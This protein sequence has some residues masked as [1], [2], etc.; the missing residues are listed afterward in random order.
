LAT[1]EGGLRG[2]EAW[3]VVRGCFT[4]LTIVLGGEDVVGG[5]CEGLP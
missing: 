1:L 2:F 4:G 5:R 3:R